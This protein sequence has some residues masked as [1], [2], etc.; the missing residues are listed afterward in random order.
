[1]ASLDW[2]VINEKLFFSLNQW[3]S[4]SRSA[5]EELFNSM[6]AEKGSQKTLTL[7]EVQAGIKAVLT[8][9]SGASMIPEGLVS[10][11]NPAVKLAFKA[12]RDLAP[13]KS[14]SGKKKRSKFATVNKTEFHAF[15]LAFRYYLE[16]AEFYETLDN[17]KED[18]QLLS[19]RECSKGLARFEQWGID[20][21]KLKQKF[22]GVDTWVSHLSYGDFAE[23]CI[24]CRFDRLDLKLD[25]SDNEEVL[26]ETSKEE[27]RDEAQ[28]KTY[29]DDSLTSQDQQNKRQVMKIFGEWDTDESGAIGEQEMIEVLKALNPRFTDEVARKLFVAADSNQDGLIDYDEFS[30][31]IF[32]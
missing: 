31:W 15:L 25:D 5:R 27:M 8:D 22:A 23:W 4:D 10:D 2:L 32:G 19:Y 9:E 28:I 26:W 7:K 29:C 6:Q 17:S 24:E 3:D 1:M 12:A 21:A 16:L 18:N 11:L 13:S 14:N 20:E 30:R